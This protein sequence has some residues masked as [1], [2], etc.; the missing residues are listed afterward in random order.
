MT[1][2]K[3]TDMAIPQPIIDDSTLT[4][5]VENAA[6][7]RAF[8][9]GLIPVTRVSDL[10]DAVATDP[11]DQ[12]RMEGW[13]Y[14]AFNATEDATIQASRLNIILMA[15]RTRTGNYNLSPE[16]VFGV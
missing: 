9:G 7:L 16:D 6:A 12:R 10:L 15:L 8:I 5:S 1:T 4:W 3:E 13:M 14:K 2:Q 11:M